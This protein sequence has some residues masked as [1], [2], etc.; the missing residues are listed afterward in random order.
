MAFPLQLIVD[1]SSWR[2]GRRKDEGW[3]NWK[4]ELK[5]PEKLKRGEKR[6]KAVESERRATALQSTCSDTENQL[7]VL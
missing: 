2:A 7:R 6:E 4:R 3:L 1:D 5:Y